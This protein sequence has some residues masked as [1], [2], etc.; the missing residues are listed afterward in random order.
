MNEVTVLAPATVANVVCGFDVLGFCLEEP[1]DLMTLRI[2]EEKTVRIINRDDFGLPT[3]PEKNVAGAVLLAILKEV[4]ADFGFEIETEKRIKPGSGIGSSAASAAGAAVAA[5]KLLNEGF[6]KSE[7]IHFAMFGEEIASNARHADNLA[8]AVYGGFT[9]VRSIDPLDIVEIDFPPLFVTILHPQ[10]EIKTAEARRILPSEVPLKTAVN[11]WANVG[12]LVSGLFKKDY[13]LIARTLEDR[14]VEPVRSR[15]IPHFDEIK[16]RS[17]QA[18]ALGGGI[19]GSGPSIF[20]L[21]ETE[22]KAME[23]EKAMRQVYQNVRFNFHTY[24][25]KI[26]GKG[27]SILDECS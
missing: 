3:E 1:Y 19:S 21:S 25:S 11:Q 10:I 23:V 15:L 26:N 17:I 12:A 14:I 22:E 2:I 8:P 27:I 7:L 24:V 18:G 4:E 5:N 6:S 9:L 20:M 16:S 13:E